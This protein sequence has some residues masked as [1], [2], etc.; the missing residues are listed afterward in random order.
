[1]AFAIK[2]N[3]LHWVCLSCRELASLAHALLSRR[4][5]Y[6]RDINYRIHAAKLNSLM[7]KEKPEVLP[8][9]ETQDLW[10]HRAKRVVAHINKNYDVAG[11]CR[12]RPR[13]ILFL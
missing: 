7:R 8:W 11:L 10:L 12:E 13:W 9:C 6:F 3:S 2:R 5:Y 1:M 4:S